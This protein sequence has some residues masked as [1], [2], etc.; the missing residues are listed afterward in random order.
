MH[1]ERSNTANSRGKTPESFEIENALQE[2]LATCPKM[3]QLPP[4]AT[5]IPFETYLFM[6]PIQ[7][8]G[9]ELN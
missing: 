5:T 2:L 6:S 9:R 8:I 7:F 4:S 1:R 3:G